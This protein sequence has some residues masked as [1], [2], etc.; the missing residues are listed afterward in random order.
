MGGWRGFRASKARH[1]GDMHPA[2]PY[3]RQHLICGLHTPSRPMHPGAP[4]S[5]VF[6]LAN[7]NYDP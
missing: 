2:A 7:C 6:M 4:P 1:W 5:Q 3:Q